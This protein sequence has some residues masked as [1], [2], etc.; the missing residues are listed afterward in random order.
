MNT[1]STNTNNRDDIFRKPQ[2]WSPEVYGD[3]C[4]YYDV[5]ISHANNDESSELVEALERCGLRVWYDKHQDMDDAMWSTRIV[6]GLRNTC[7][8]LCFLGSQPLEKHIWVKAEINAGRTAEEAAGCQ[9]VFVTHA[10]SEQEVP[11]WLADVQ[12]Y[13][14]YKV[15]ALQKTAVQKFAARL[16]NLNRVAVDTSSPPHQVLAQRARAI[17]ILYED[18]IFAWQKLDSAIKSGDIVE[19]L[20]AYT[21]GALE[22]IGQASVLEEVDVS[23]MTYKFYQL[24]MRSSS[25]SQEAELPLAGADGTTAR[26]LADDLGLLASLPTSTLTVDSRGAA[27]IVL[28]RLAEAGVER[29]FD[30]L[31]SCL[32]WEWSDTLVEGVSNFLGKHPE[33]QRRDEAA[34]ILLKSDIRSNTWPIDL[35]GDGDEVIRLRYH[36]RRSAAREIS[37]LAPLKRSHELTSQMD[38]AIEALS[39][40]RVELV[41]SAAIQASGIANSWSN[42]FWMNP[43]AQIDAA[44]ILPALVSKCAREWPANHRIRLWH[45]PFEGT[46]V[47]PLEALHHTHGDACRASDAITDFISALEAP[48]AEHE[49][50]LTNIPESACKYHCVRLALKEIQVRR[51]TIQA[52]RSRATITRDGDQLDIKVYPDD[53]YKTSN[54][55]EELRS[56]TLVDPQAPPKKLQHF[57]DIARRVQGAW[58]DI[59]YC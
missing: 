12:I 44:A 14:R 58:Q 56:A 28:E 1:R 22:V 4:F 17:K 38:Y 39:V 11:S 59:P 46:V 20:Q 54:G 8:I 25:L 48:I 26:L 21:E 57:I 10:G 55:L 27:Y 7:S 35:L 30:V 2:F 23:A 29:A 42:Y 3:R 36:A 18:K 33:Y 13:L 9:R 31:R 49:V 43:E 19:I 32:R 6:W 41:F 37:A 24:S 50:L 52:L 40:A 45:I 34:L 47:G 15:G 5:F 16:R 53:H 51:S